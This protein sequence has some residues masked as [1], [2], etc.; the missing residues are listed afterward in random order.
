MSDTQNPLHRWARFNAVG[1]LG[2]LLQL[3]TLALLNRVFPRHYLLTSASAVEL[4]LLHNFLWHLHY[5]WPDRR[6]TTSRLRQCLRFHLSNGSVSLLGNLAL[7]RL[8]VGKVH[9]PTLLANLLAILCCSALN[10][11]VGNNW[12]FT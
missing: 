2:A 8:L 3:S 4:T 5:T 1:M 7:M 12:V 6:H 11:F 10:F 9:L